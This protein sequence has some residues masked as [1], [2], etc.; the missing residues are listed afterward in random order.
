MLRTE[1]SVDSLNLDAGPQAQAHRTLYPPH[2]VG[3]LA[4]G[5]GASSDCGRMTSF[6]GP[7][8]R[9]THTAL[10]VLTGDRAYKVKKPVVLDFVDFSTVESRRIGCQD[11]LALNRRL[12]PDVY[13]D[14]AAVTGSDPVAL[15]YM[16]VMRRMP[17]DRRLTSMIE[18]GE[19]VEAAI[20]DVVH[21]VARLHTS[22]P[23]D[24]AYSDVG[25]ADFLIGHWEQCCNELRAAGDAIVPSEDIDAIEM[26]ARIYIEG[27]GRLL[28]QRIA[29][30]KI[31]DGHGDLQADDIFVLD[32]GVRILDC[33]EF[34]AAL[35]W[36]DVLN[37]VAFLAM[38]M[39]RLGRPDLAT[40]VFDAHR[41]LTGDEYPSSLAHYYV[42][43]RAIVR[44]FM[45][46]IRSRQG[47]DSAAGRCRLLVA[48][49]RRH[50]DA[51]AVKLVL[52]GGLPGT[53]K[54]TLSRG[55]SARD[56]I[57]AISSDVVRVEV[58]V[59]AI[60]NADSRALPD[61][62]YSDAAVASIYHVMIERAEHALRSGRTVVLDASWKSAALRAMARSVGE[63]ASCDVVELRCVADA[64]VAEARII[65]R[66]GLGDDLS[67][68]TVDVARMMLQNFD[69]WPEA[70]AVMTN[71]PST[72]A[73][74]FALGAVRPRASI[75][76]L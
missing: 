30:G 34:Q 51:G 72:D 39:E 12:A 17:D 53:G 10:V 48:I 26:M 61:D 15:D 2:D 59:G 22:I 24:P 66:S 35:R 5:I 65:E 64:L 11:E 56:D 14:V 63:N 75:E 38:D 69:P 76:G 8:I 25:R 27:R 70:I 67:E 52:I 20:R 44:A 32:D 68:A 36:G 47:D 28:E 74:A 3:E 73:I 40:V 7:A 54:S 49:A 43:Y 1:E 50:L 19:P 71:D 57:V 55:L 42:A 37:D 13:L 4:F 58:A 16:V 62:R 18:H 31:R 29:D 23:L 46:A 33:L 45:N 9:E 41:A 21:Q 60:S 6:S